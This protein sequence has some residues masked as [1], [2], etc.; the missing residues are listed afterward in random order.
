MIHRYNGILL[1]HK[2]NE[3]MPFPGTL[4]DL[5]I[6]ILSEERQIKINIISHIYRILKNDTNCDFP[7]GPVAKI[8]HG[9]C[10]EHSSDP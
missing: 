2:K 7:G 9:Q 6:V 3:I 1:I 10:R 8:P 4:M 5:E